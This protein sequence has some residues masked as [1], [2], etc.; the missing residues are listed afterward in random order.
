MILEG[1]PLERTKSGVMF[2]AA[3]TA[4]SIGTGMGVQRVVLPLYVKGFISQEFAYLFIVLLPILSFGLFKGFADLL[5]GYLAD[6][7]GRKITV[8]MGTSTFLIGT[9]LLIYSVNLIMIAASLLLMG[10]SQGLIDSGIMIIL[11][12]AGGKER[13]GLSLGIMESSVYGGYTVGAFLGGYVSEVSSLPDAFYITLVASAIAVV[14]SVTGI[15][16]TKGEAREDVPTLHA[17][18]MCLRSS[19]LRLTYFLGHAAQFSDALVWG[20][21]PIY[22]SSI[23]LDNIRIGIIQGLN[24]LAW[25]SLMPFS[26]RISDAVGRRIPTFLGFSLKAL[27]IYLIHSFENS[28]YLALASVL[29]GVGVG[30][31]YPI[32]PAISADAAPPAVRGRSIGLYTSL[33]DFGYITGALTLGMIGEIYGFGGTFV[34]T[35]LLLA[36]G[37]PLIF[38]MKETRPFWPAF[39]MV[40]EHASIILKVIESFSSMVESYSK[41]KKDQKNFRLIKQYENQADE[42]K[43][44]IDRQLWLS[45]LSGQDKADF[46][47]LVGRVDRVAS[48]AL[49]ASRRL[50]TLDP[51]T[52]PLSIRK[53]MSEMA[54]VSR[55]IANRLYRAVELIRID[56]EDSLE[57]VSEIDEIET[58]FDELHQRAMEELLHTKMDL[59]PLL[60]LRD[61]I[62]L[63]ENMVDAVE[64]AS[65]VLR[66]IAFKH[67]AWPV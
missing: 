27:S 16:E 17:Y 50:K 11:S 35:S 41:G 14:L 49:G 13:H 66:V 39:D 60:N 12:E 46:A 37:S 56:L 9:A 54:K 26:G 25:A 52:I 18:S 40:V 55:W 24:T 5:A 8:I 1:N 10:W 30:L 2:A 7:L 34:I 58:I 20:L 67:M 29:L 19:T 32:L 43:I 53:L 57:T 38:L 36:L 4:L 31:Y 21:L 44:A 33:R 59:M 22:L 63:T 65:D 6:R 23:G 47:R 45:S 62:E 15:S 51:D 42:L 3:M 64:D 28:L 48:F 61:F